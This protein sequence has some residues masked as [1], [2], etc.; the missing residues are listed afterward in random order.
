MIDVAANLFAAQGFAA[1]GVAQIG[2]EVGLARGALYYYIGSK[3]AL[4]AAI[5]DRVMDPLL[6]EATFISGMEANP[7]VRLVLLSEC[8]MGHIVGRRTDVWVFLH[9]YHHL[10]GEA[11]ERF[12]AKRKRFESHVT[13][14]LV[15]GIESHGYEISDARL[16]T[17]SWLNLHNYTYLWLEREK[18]SDSRVLAWNYSTI[19]LRGVCADI[20]LGA[21]KK[22]VAQHRRSVAMYRD[23]ADAAAMPSA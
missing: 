2:D 20:D 23:T 4:L 17:L 18:Y 9:E 12:S 21:L 8:L 10:T 22:E 7:A 3:E 1:T 19:F 16:A 5:H 11:H 6:A 13:D 14:L 15:E